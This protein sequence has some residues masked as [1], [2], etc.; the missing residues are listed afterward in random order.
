MYMYFCSIFAH[1]Y[2]VSDTGAIKMNKI[3][4]LASGSLYSGIS[5]DI[6]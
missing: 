1:A 5:N 3:Y 4:F 2:W 6:T